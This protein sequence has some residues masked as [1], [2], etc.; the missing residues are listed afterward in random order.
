MA[1]GITEVIPPPPLPHG[2]ARELYSL[3]NKCAYFYIQVAIRKDTPTNKTHTGICLPTTH[4][5]FNCY[6]Y[7]KRI[8][9]QTKGD[10][11]S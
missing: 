5:I 11:K 7:C 4:I 8:A 3:I 1:C 10:D 6:P 2:I 9:R